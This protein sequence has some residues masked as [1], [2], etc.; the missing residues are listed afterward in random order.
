[1]NIMS[2]WVIKSTEKF[3]QDKVDGYFAWVKVEYSK[4]TYNSVIGSALAYSI[5]QEEYLR[6]LLTDGKIPM[7]NNYAKQAIRPFTIARKNLVLM[8]F[9]HGQNQFSRKVQ[10]GI[11]N[12][13]SL[14]KVH[15]YEIA[16]K[17]AVSFLS[18]THEWGLTEKVIC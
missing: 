5:N 11:K 16:Y 18:G 6:M 7:D 12:L 2:N 3:L 17:I 13:N 14:I 15:I 8:E 9:F 10:A 1:M 4:V